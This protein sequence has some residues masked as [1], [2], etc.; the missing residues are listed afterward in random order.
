MR[1]NPLARI[2]SIYEK[3]KQCVYRNKISREARIRYRL[4]NR[5][6][7]RWDEFD[8]SLRERWNYWSRGFLTRSS[9]IYPLESWEDRTFVTDT[10][11][12]RSNQINIWHGTA[13]RNKLLFARQLRSLPN[14]YHPTVFAIVEADTVVPEQWDGSEPVSIFD[15]LQ[16]K[17]AVVL[18]PIYGY[19]GQGIYT[20]Q[21]PNP[22]TYLLN[23]EETTENDVRSLTASLSRYLVTEY[24]DQAAYL[25]TIYPEA[26]NTIR[27]M[28]IRPSSTESP[29]VIAAVQ[30]LGTDETSPTDNWSNNGLAAQIDLNTGELM[31]AVGLRDGER[32]TFDEHPDTNARITGL[33]VPCWESLYER[34]VEAASAFPELPYLA[35]DIVPQDEG[36]PAVIEANAFP[37]VDIL[38]L[39]EPLLENEAVNAFFEDHGVI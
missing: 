1:Y 3:T 8:V 7:A 13:T 39:R 19:R 29:Q 34:T 26:T 27:L 2:E 18:K 35:W 33:R 12:E 23:G 6:L 16:R 36:P 15:I 31:A 20:I 38:Q 28:T 21:H 32:V 10:E 22:D 9:V 24:V 4:A 30:R 17:G 5:E 14:V 37:D 25:N 11:R